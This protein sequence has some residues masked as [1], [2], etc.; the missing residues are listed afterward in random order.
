MVPETVD[1]LLGRASFARYFNIYMCVRTTRML[2]LEAMVSRFAVQSG[3]EYIRELNSIKIK[4]NLL[5]RHSSRIPGQVSVR[6][7]GPGLSGN[8]DLE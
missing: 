5:H 8:F 6:H 4:D 7:L 1:L 2:M 3:T